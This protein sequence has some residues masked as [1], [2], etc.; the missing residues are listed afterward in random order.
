MSKNWY[1][2]IGLATTIIASL[3]LLGILKAIFGL[4]V[5]TNLFNTGITPGIILGIAFA[6]ISYWVYKRYL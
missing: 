3:L 6:V 1:Y 2:S 5:E 4:G